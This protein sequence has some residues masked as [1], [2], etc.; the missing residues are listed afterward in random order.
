MVL[1]Q[2]VPSFSLLWLKTGFVGLFVTAVIL[3]E[4]R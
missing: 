3:P 2:N 1:V 4:I